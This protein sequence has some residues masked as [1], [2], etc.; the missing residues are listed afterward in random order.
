V[1]KAVLFYSISSHKIRPISLLAAFFLFA[2]TGSALAGQLEDFEWDASRRHQQNVS[3]TRKSTS[4]NKSSVSD[5]II[6]DMAG[7]CLSLGCAP[8]VQGVLGGLFSGLASGGAQSWKRVDAEGTGALNPD[9]GLRKSGE[10]LLPFLRLDALYQNVEG[11]V[12]A[13]DIRFEAGYGPLGFQVRRT[14]Y[15]EKDPITSLELTEYYFLYRMS[16]GSMVEIDLGLGGTELKGTQFN[17]GL[18]VTVPVLYHPS[19][20]FGIELRP[21]WSSI[22]ESSIQDV[23][24]AVLVGMRYISVKAGYRW[25]RSPHQSL[26][27]PEAGLSLRW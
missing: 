26:D 14:I 17:S 1:R 20:F 18:S 21:A 12:T 23:D 2:A 27:G 7:E 22:N 3:E 5:D 11:D 13:K 15:D 24:A 10:A 16:S 19:Q 8:L 9:S 25:M 4:G 6:S